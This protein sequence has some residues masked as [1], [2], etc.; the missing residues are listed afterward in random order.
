MKTLNKFSTFLVAAAVA[1]GSLGFTACSDDDDN[2]AGNKDGVV[3]QYFGVMPATRGQAIEIH[4]QNLHKVKTV[5]FPIDVDVTDFTLEGGNL[6]RVV[7]PEEAL[8]GHLRLVTMSN[9]TIVSKSLLSYDEEITVTEVTPV[10]G[11]L[12]GDIVTVK[13]DCVYNIAS[14]TFSNGVEVPSIDFVS[15]SRRELKVAVPRGAQSG[16][17]S[18]TDGAENEPW[19]YTYPTPLEIISPEVTALDKTDYDF[20]E[21]MTISGSNLQYVDKITFPGGVELASD[22]WTVAEDGSSI[23]LEVPEECADGEITLTLASGNTITTPA[24]TLPLVKIEKTYVDGNE[25]TAVEDLEVGMTLRF[26][27]QNLDRVKRLFLP[28][29]TQNKFTDYTL[30]GNTAI[31]F[32]VTDKFQ[33]GNVTFYQNS[34]VAPTVGVAM[35]VELPYIWK[36][37]VSLGGWSGN[38]YPATWDAGLWKKFI[39]REGAVN[40][41]GLMTIYFSHD[42]A[43]EGD[44]ILKL[45]YA[46]WSTAWSK[47]SPIDPGSGGVIID[48][49]E[50]NFKVEIAQADIDRFIAEGSFVIYGCGLNLT[51]IKY[52]PGKTIDGGD[53]PTPS[54]PEPIEVWSGNVDLSWGAGGRVCIP[55]EYF[56]TA[57]AGSLL[58]IH[59]NCKA[60]VW[61]QAQIND[62]Q[63]NTEWN[64]EAV[65][66]E[67][68]FDGDGNPITKYTAAGTWVPSDMFG[69]NTFQDYHEADFI[70]TQANIDKILANRQDCDQESAIDCGII[71]Q[72][73]DV[74]ITKVEI[75]PQK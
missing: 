13:G 3:L 4:G 37:N 5:V 60:G 21:P 67:D 47:V 59:F 69:W 58:R 70:I 43:V 42:D 11:L 10:T 9:D 39:E 64:W 50:K 55:A 48:P 72:G 1:A 41:P 6:I 49:A 56:E 15:A 53:T 66:P 54:A 57:E 22:D 27:G 40:K 71:F 74:N 75:V 45:T 63:W 19:E 73:S 33:D 2:L 7:V 51:A 46:D 31:S 24:F 28:G 12:P 52:E 8:A 14:V 44:H 32:A 68:V 36:G 61:C 16:D 17:I 18:F 34:C 23:K 35:L 20:F 25:V 65:M 30:E 26:E 38:L 62:G 29:D